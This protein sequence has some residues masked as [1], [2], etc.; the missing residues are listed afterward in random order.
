MA[1]MRC[2]TCGSEHDWAELQPSFLH[3]DAYLEVPEEERE[4]RTISGSD[5]CRVRDAADTE[6]RYFLRGLLP[7]PI[8]GE[9][10]PCSWGIWVEVTLPTFER[11]RELWDAPDQAAE[12]PF[13]ATLANSVRGYP[14]TLGLAGTLQLTG[15]TTAPRFA[16]APS[17][18]HPLATEQREGVFAER[19]LE[20]LHEH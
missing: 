17:V 10:A 3:P 2:A 19:V 12:P 11:V 1:T 14:S 9:P 6:R 7:I 8:R 5:D 18:D 16:F 20:W 13:Q 4:H 15:P